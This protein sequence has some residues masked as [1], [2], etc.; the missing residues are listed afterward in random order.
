MRRGRGLFVRRRDDRTDLRA[1][2][3]AL[4]APARVAR[5]RAAFRAAA[6]RRPR[7]ATR[8]EI[9]A[10]RRRREPGDGSRRPS[11]CARRGAGRRSRPDADDAEDDRADRRLVISPDAYSPGRGPAPPRVR[12]DDARPSCARPSGSSTPCPAASSGG[13]RAARSSTRTAATGAAR[14][15]PAQPRHRRPAPGLGL[16]AADPRAALAGRAVRHLRLDGAP[17]TAAA[18]LRPGAVGSLGGTHRV[19]RVRDPAHARHPAARDRDPDRALAR[20]SDA[21][22]DW[23][24]GTRIGESFR[25]ST[26]I[27]R[28]GAAH[29][30]RRDRRLRRLGPRRSRARR[31]RDGPPPAQL[32]SAR[33]AQPAR[34]DA[35]IPAAGRRDA[36]RLPVRRRLPG[37]RH[38]RQPRASRR[39]PRRRARRRHAPRQRRRRAC[40]TPRAGR[41][42]RRRAAGRPRRHADR[43]VR[44]EAIR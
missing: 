1:V 14:D 28:G 30:G 25:T 44:R 22:N 27:G 10:A 38:G 33:L 5:S 31:D 41:P 40:G 34:R 26:S 7:K 16:A 36:G 24:G 19:V 15:V 8:T 18:A 4:V 17:L 39:D 23:A 21:V 13:G 11:R 35:R 6:D 12:P 43:S 2:F 20:V 9:A 37:G 3:D 29:L 42:G 32:P